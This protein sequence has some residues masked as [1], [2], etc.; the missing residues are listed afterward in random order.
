MDSVYD[1]IFSSNSNSPNRKIRF[2]EKTIN[3]IAMTGFLVFA[4]FVGIV[5]DYL[6]LKDQVTNFEITEVENKRLQNQYNETL[7][8]LSS[9]QV[10]LQK[11]DS[12]TQKINRI[13]T[14]L[15]NKKLLYKLIPSA[16]ET[17]DA[18][19]P[20]ELASSPLYLDQKPKSDLLKH[21]SLFFKKPFLADHYADKEFELGYDITAQTETALFQSQS[22]EQEVLQQWAKMSEQKNILQ[23]T[24]IIKPAEG[25][26]SSKYGYRKDPMT[27]RRKMHSGLDIVAP[28]GTPI[29]A[30]A[31][32]KVKFAGYKGGYGKVVIISHGYGL[33]TRFA[34]LSKIVVKNG[35][36]VKRYQ[37]LGGMGSTGKS[38]GT[39]LHY[40]VRIKGVA[41]DPINYILEI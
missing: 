1:I 10:T 24:P 29:K 5:F 8:K 40:E 17:Q 3:I 20:E 21:E 36:Y 38:T 30:P 31:D 35:Q 41:V 22:I 12:T 4:L 7:V 15:N 14:Q 19:T 37:V 34:H 26:F 11:V 23:A 13:T 2:T 16:Y 33:E 32:G 28:R 6:Y 18:V 9:A 25:W 27:K 39:H